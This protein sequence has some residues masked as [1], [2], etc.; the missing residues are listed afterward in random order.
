MSG[1]TALASGA[2]FKG[3]LADDL[4]ILVDVDDSDAVARETNSVLLLHTGDAIDETV[5]NAQ[6]TT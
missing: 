5:R 1:A 4:D 2:A 6:V 3:H